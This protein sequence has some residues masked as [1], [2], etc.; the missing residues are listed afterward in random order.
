MDF[1][2][3][4]PSA[5]VTSSLRCRGGGV[6]GGRATR[7]LCSGSRAN[8]EAGYES[9]G[10]IHAERIRIEMAGRQPPER[11]NQNFVGR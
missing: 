3:I 2:V 8:N 11:A 1:S 10:F 4:A 6:G 7:K 5:V 9:R